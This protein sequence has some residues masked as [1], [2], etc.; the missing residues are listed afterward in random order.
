MQK[1]KSMLILTLLFSSIADG[2]YL[3]SANTNACQAP[4]ACLKRIVFP[5]YP[6]LARIAHDA[7][8]VTA[9][10]K[11]SDSKLRILKISGGNKYFDAAI[12]TAL[13]NW[14]IS[15]TRPFPATEFLITF[16]F[17]ISATEAAGLVNEID[18][19]TSTLT[20]WSE[21]KF[22]ETEQLPVATNP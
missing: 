4:L 12:H 20:I 10:L 3:S 11:Y 18:L 1:S 13:S 21:I 2:Q 8:I 15:S 16:D 7:R 17:R 22:T 14:Q 9:S 19:D 6:K 5:V